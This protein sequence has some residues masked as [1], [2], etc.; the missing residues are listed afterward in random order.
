VTI[1]PSRHGGSIPR[2]DGATILPVTE[3]VAALAN[4]GRCARIPGYAHWNPHA[5]GAAPSFLE[6]AVETLT[7]AHQAIRV[8]AGNPQ[9]LEFGWIFNTFKI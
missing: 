6:R 4:T 5:R 8:A 7:D 9:Q 3:K 1:L 2:D